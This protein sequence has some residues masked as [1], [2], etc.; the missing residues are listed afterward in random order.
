VKEKSGNN[1]ADN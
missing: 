1:I